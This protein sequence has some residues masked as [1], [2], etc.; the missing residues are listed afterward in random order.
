MGDRV[1][2]HSGENSLVRYRQEANMAG[3]FK[4]FGREKLYK[5]WVDKEGL[6]PDDLP[7]DLKKDTGDSTEVDDDLD[8]GVVTR[9]EFRPRTGRQADNI[10]ASIS[11]RFVFIMA[12]VIVVLLVIVSVLATVLIMR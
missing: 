1:H 8:D 4:K 6:S 5:Q 7:P 12:L 9:R 3:F 2:I 11:M 10:S